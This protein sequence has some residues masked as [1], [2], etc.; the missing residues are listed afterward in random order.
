[1]FIKINELPDEA[2]AALKKAAPLQGESQM[3]KKPYE[4]AFQ[5]FQRTTD[6]KY[7][8]S[9]F[10]FIEPDENGE[11]IMETVTV[12]EEDMFTVRAQIK[13]TYARII[14]LDFEQGCNE[15]KCFWCNFT[16]DHLVGKTVTNDTL[17][18]QAIM[19]D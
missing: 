9:Y 13:D 17:M 5:E 19:E 10:D 15:E 7:Q 8:D 3:K 1:M 18:S 14:N 12:T 4:E 11:F 2:L 16:K 6:W